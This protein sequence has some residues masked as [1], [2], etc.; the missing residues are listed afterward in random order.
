MLKKRKIDILDLNLPS[1]SASIL[2]FR[3]KGI[4]LRKKYSKDYSVR[5]SNTG[6][7]RQLFVLRKLRCSVLCKIVRSWEKGKTAA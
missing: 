5:K 1:I 6:P 4:K 2:S 3:E 7:G